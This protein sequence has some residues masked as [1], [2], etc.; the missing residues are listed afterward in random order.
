MCLGRDGKDLGLDEGAVARLSPLLTCGESESE[1]FD[2]LCRPTCRHVHVHCIDC[3]V[4][5]YVLFILCLF[6]CLFVCTL[7][8]W[9]VGSGFP[10]F[11]PSSTIYYLSYVM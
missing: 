7:R 2:L 8:V 4:Y 10:S 9:C 6:V 1:M 11:F 5:M 3:E